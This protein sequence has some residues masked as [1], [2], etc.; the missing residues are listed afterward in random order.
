MER[1]IYDGTFEGLLTVLKELFSNRGEEGEILAA[2]NRR[3]VLFYVD[4]QVETDFL[5]AELMLKEI[6]DRI[7]P[8]ALRHVFYAYLSEEKEAGNLIY[9]YLKKGFAL[10]RQVDFN[11]ADADVAA[12]HA[13]SMRVGREK[14]RLM[15][16]A[17]FRLL[18]GDIYYA[19][20]EPDGDV[21]VLLAPHFRKRMPEENWIIHDLKR[22]KAVLY[23]KKEWLISALKA[24]VRPEKAAEEKK[25]QL[26][27]KKYFG[28]I[29]VKE[30]KNLRLQA[31]FMPKKYWRY[32]V[33]MED[34]S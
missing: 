25:F 12:V 29:A 6:K 1:I 2:R 11:V 33:E 23:N 24:G 17:R 7:S 5:Q 20:L 21:L 13:L 15:G 8:A 30:R 4:R 19:P 32:L 14:H 28:S 22:E 3:P 18:K 27:W 16:L 31:S 9:R 10:G 34:D 26:L